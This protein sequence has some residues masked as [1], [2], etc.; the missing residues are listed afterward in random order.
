MHSHRPERLIDRLRR[1][2][3]VTRAGRDEDDGAH[4]RRQLVGP[5]D[6]D[7]HRGGL[8]SIACSILEGRVAAT[9]ERG[10]NASAQIYDQPRRHFI[11]NSGRGRRV[12][13]DECRAGRCAGS[14]SVPISSLRR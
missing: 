3:E 8:A 14:L 10:G 13:V 7:R 5:V 12:A 2:R 9:N 1:R 4:R 6:V 11:H